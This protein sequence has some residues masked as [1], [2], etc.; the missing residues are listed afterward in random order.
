MALLLVVFCFAV[1]TV[2]Y[3]VN[4]RAANRKIWNMGPAN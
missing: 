2:V 4:R 1:L 3:G